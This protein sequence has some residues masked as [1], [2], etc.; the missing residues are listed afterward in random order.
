MPKWVVSRSLNDVGPNATLLSD[1]FE[2]AIR[3]IKSEHAERD[4]DIEVGGP[5]LAAL[6][7]ERGLIDEYH[8]FLHPVV[9]GHGRPFFA[10]VQP[11]LRLLSSERIG[12]RAIKLTYAPA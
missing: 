12:E 1:D 2:A 11:T 3:R 7:A 5:K 9:L 4:G 6:L 10:G 8:V